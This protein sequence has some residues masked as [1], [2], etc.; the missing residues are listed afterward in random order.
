VAPL[1]RW[2]TVAFAREQTIFNARL[3]TT[4]RIGGF[5]AIDAQRSSANPR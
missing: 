4:V 1:T 2:R 5:A 3:L